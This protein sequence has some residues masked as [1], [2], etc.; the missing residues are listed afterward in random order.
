MS[1]NNNSVNSAD[2]DHE[3]AH[4]LQVHLPDAPPADLLHGL[5]AHGSLSEPGPEHPRNHRS[6]D[7]R[8]REE[9]QAKV[10]R[11]NQSVRGA[12]IT[13]YV[14]ICIELLFTFWG[15]TIVYHQL[16]LQSLFESPR[17]HS[18]R[19]R[20]RAEDL[21]RLRSLELY[22]HLVHL[23]LLR[24]DLDKLASFLFWARWL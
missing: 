18:P 7:G 16:N 3:E 9:S 21:V 12:L 11:F 15:I 17:W 5:P 10:Q 14:F 13:T 24:V 1:D 23:R 20:N 8:R 19:D 2:E 22:L 4:R 6:G